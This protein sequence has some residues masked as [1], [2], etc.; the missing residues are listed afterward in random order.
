MSVQKHIVMKSEVLDY[1]INIKN[2]N[3]LSSISKAFEKIAEEHKT[4]NT[5]KDEKLVKNITDK[6][7]KELSKD[8][9][10]ISLVAK[11]AD[12]NSQIALLMLNQ[13]LLDSDSSYYSDRISN[14]FIASQKIIEDKLSSLK[15]K[16]A[17]RRSKTLFNVSSMEIKER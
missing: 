2:E 12:K 17:S 11:S 8:V 9:Q 1:L 13:L 6:V 7:I 5:I 3:H 4:Y 14:Q 16:K 10:D 15:T